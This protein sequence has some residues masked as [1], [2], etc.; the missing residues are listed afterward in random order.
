TGLACVTDAIATWQQAG[1]RPSKLL[2]AWNS[3]LDSYR[4]SFPDKIMSASLIPTSAAFPAIAEDGTIIMGPRPDLT[5]MMMA[6]ATAAVPGRL[7]VQFDFLMPGEAASPDVID[8]AHMLGTMAAFQ[9]NEYL[10][11]QGAACAE[12]VSNPTPCT[13]ATYLTMLET[14]IYP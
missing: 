6:S 4:K 2:L 9:T 5:Q 11:G 10:G 1:Y 12:P 13:A 7:V 8:D 14:G 3:I